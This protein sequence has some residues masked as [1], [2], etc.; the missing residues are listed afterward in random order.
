[1]DINWGTREEEE[2]AATG[3]GG[4]A[5]RLGLSVV[6][7]KGWGDQRFASQLRG[8]P[9]ARRDFSFTRALHMDIGIAEEMQRTENVPF[10]R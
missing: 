5:N 2:E 8:S 4:V 1:V 3:N 9:R 6:G 10:S 7:N